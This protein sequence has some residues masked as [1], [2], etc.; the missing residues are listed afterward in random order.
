MDFKSA[1]VIIQ[2]LTILGIIVSILP[3]VTFLTGKEYLNKF[4]WFTSLPN[5]GR[6]LIVFGLPS[7]CLTTAITLSISAPDK[8]V[9]QG[10][11]VI[12]RDSSAK[13]E[14]SVIPNIPAQHKT[15]ISN[16]V[17]VIVRV[18]NQQNDE[19]SALLAKYYEGKSYHVTIGATNDISAN[20]NTIAGDLTS[21]EPIP[22][23]SKQFVNYTLK[24][25]LKIHKGSKTPC[26]QRV[27]EE[28]LPLAPGGSL[29]ALIQQA[30]ADFLRKIEAAN[31]TP[32]CS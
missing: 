3:L 5:W 31:I 24:L 30:F 16:G 22:D 14:T 25:I 32:I 2:C 6:K 8:K 1:Q 21:S 7:V 20:N 18:N 4:N 28:K 12:P 23:E 15:P 19:F 11:P 10:K 9:A 17:Q 26:A 13:H 29:D 27:Y